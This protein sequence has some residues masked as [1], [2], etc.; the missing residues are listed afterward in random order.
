MITIMIISSPVV[1]GELVQLGGQPDLLPRQLLLLRHQAGVLLLGCINLV[2]MS[3]NQ[4]HAAVISD[5]ILHFLVLGL[6]F[7][8][9]HLHRV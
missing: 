8:E 9:L 3:F 5:L 7:I 6:Q 4:S 2:R 1:C